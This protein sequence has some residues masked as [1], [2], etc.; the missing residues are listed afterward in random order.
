MPNNSIFQIKTNDYIKEVNM[1][2]VN[3][4]RNFVTVP[5]SHRRKRITLLWMSLKCSVT[6]IDVIIDV[7]LTSKGLKA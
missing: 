1:V 7:L 4:S 3:C 2:L 5:F 6:D